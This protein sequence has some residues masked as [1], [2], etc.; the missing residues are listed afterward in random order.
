MYNPLRSSLS[1]YGLL[2]GILIFLMN[3]FCYAQ[4]SITSFAPTSG[5]IGTTVS[6][7][8]SNFSSTPANN[9]VYFG[10]VKANVTIAS[11]GSLTVTVPY[12]AT[13]EPI[14]VTVNGYTAYAQ[15]PFL[16]TFAN[17]GNIGSNSFAQSIDSTTDLHPND[18]V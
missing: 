5:A 10:A 6:I 7:S 13:Y 2:L 15:K 1:R 8:G 17:A 14:S 18:L 9:I 16:V 12:G 4:P 3:H 11:A